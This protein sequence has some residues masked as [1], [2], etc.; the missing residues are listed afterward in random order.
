MAIGIRNCVWVSARWKWKPAGERT[1]LSSCV[2]KRAKK[3]Y[4][5]YTPGKRTQHVNVALIIMISIFSPEANHVKAILNYWL[6][7]SVFCYTCCRSDD[8]RR[9]SI[10]KNIVFAWQFHS[11][12][13]GCLN[14]N[15]L[16]ISRSNLR[17][18]SMII[19]F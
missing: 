10:S 9:R 15:F 12:I 6:L 14:S 18:V 13:S 4:R 8:K 2:K 7:V 16:S 17:K 5:V 3:L 1:A 19:Y 11:A